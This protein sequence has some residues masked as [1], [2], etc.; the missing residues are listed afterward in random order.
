MSFGMLCWTALPS[1][2]LVSHLRARFLSLEAVFTRSF[3][4]CIKMVMDVAFIPDFFL[5][6]RDEVNWKPRCTYLSLSESVRADLQLTEEELIAAHE[7][8]L[9]RD[10]AKTQRHREKKRTEN[11]E[12]FLKNN[13]AQHQSWSEKNP[14]RVNEIAADVRKKAKEQQRFRCEL[15][16]HNAA[17]QFALDLH[18]QSRSH[19][20]AE[21]NGRK[22]LQPLSSTAQNRRASRA[23]AVANRTYYCTTCKKACTST[24]DLKRHKSKQ[25][26]KDMVA[27]SHSSSH[28]HT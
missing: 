22:V 23:A 20:D 4:A 10:A 18:L 1:P 12:L 9:K 5:W 26:H 24:T 8:R 15:C 3:C 27:K 25:K 11:E 6:S 16:D 17:T 13:L 21:R 14:G 28:Q 2:Q 19:L 7:L